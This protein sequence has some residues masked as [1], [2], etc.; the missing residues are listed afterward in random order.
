MNTRTTP[1]SLD[2]FASELEHEVKEN[3][4]ASWLKHAPDP[5]NGGFIGYADRTWRPDRGAVKAGILNTRILWTFSRAFRAFRE[6][7][8]R[9][10]AERA[11]RYITERFLDPVHGGLYWDLT[12][13][14]EPRTPKKQIYAQSFAIYAFAEYHRA[15]GDPSAL[16]RAVELFRLIE[17]HSRDRVHGGYLEACSRE[18]RPLPDMRLSERDMNSPKSMNTHLHVLEAYTALL[19]A[20]DDPELRSALTDL[21]RATLGRI[22]NRDTG[23]F[24]LFSDLEWRP[25]SDAISY[26]HDIE[27]SWLL[28]EAAEAADSPPLMDE[29]KPVALGMARAVLEEGIDSDGGIVNEAG[30]A[31][32]TDRSRDWWPQ[33]EAMVG[34]FNTWQL[35]GDERYLEAAL[36][37]W[38]FIRRFIRDPEH[39]DWFWGVAERGAGYREEKLGPWK[40]PYHNA[41]ACIEILERVRSRS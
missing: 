39:G 11:F 30:P 6:P 5:L 25:M 37:S 20:W 17:K 33:A 1:G 21:I 7:G 2:A 26:G 10:A 9:T 31:G 8:Y 28:C 23:H 24:V 41:R 22:V 18:W 27:G 36:G 3:I 19:R 16:D 38:S 29:V 13:A 35:S 14:G 32:W 34:F 15:T 12:A 4:L 40:C